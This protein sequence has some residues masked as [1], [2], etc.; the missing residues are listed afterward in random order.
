M[1]FRPLAALL[2]AGS[3]GAGDTPSFVIV[4]A[5]DLGVDNVRVYDAHPA[6]ARTDRLDQ[7]AAEG[8]RFRNAYAHPTCS[9]SRASLLAGLPAWRTKIGS[10]VEIGQTEPGLNESHRGFAE[11][12]GPEYRRVVLGKW[13]ISSRPEI[14]TRLP[15]EDF[16]FDSFQGTW[17]NLSGAGNYRSFPKVIDGGAPVTTNEYLTTNTINDAIREIE[18]A[19][20]PL[21]LLANLHAPHAPW[22]EP[23]PHLHSVDVSTGTPKVLY[24]AM[25]E[26]MDTEI[27]RLLD[28]LDASPL[29]DSTY[30]IFL[31]DNGTPK[32]VTTAPW[33]PNRAKGSCYEGGVHVPLIVRGPGVAAGSVC[34]GLVH[35]S[36]LFAT[37]TELAGR[38]LDHAP[39]ESVSLAPYLAGHTGSLREFVHSELYFLNGNDTP[40]VWIR[41][42]RGVRYKLID[43]NEP[44]NPFRPDELYD[45]WN[46]PLELNNL[47]DGDVNSLTPELQAEYGKL[48]R[49]LLLEGAGFYQ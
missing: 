22:H 49:F 8:M 10:R 39:A 2:L 33:D 6:P 19:S 45:L 35:I 7:L 29:A 38:P 18:H 26:S 25:V 32:P 30:V 23:P 28:A 27:G 16:G 20:G 37:I 43:F 34:D 15:H 14:G 36:D 24:K 48:K 31:A 4:M 17:F 11:V 3:A 40:N 12:I 46:D 41:A 44:T 42:A 1:K 13:H 5:D 9:P 47:F 21:L